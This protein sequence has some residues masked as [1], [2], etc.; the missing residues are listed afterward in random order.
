[1]SSLIKSTFGGL[2]TKA[3]LKD[4]EEFLGSHPVGSGKLAAKQVRRGGTFLKAGYTF[5]YR[6]LGCLAFSLKF[7]PNINQFLS[8]CPA[9]DLIFFFPNS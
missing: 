6:Q 5:F 9:S 4:A 2:K 3:G 8:N 1:M 7:W